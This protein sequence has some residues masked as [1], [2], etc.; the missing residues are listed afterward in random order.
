MRRA[1]LLFAVILL[2]LLGISF[3]YNQIT[4]YKQRA[5][6]AEIQAIV[7]DTITVTP[8]KQ[9]VEKNMEV[10]TSIVIP[11]LRVQAPIQPVGQDRKGRMATIPDPKT[12]AW[13][14]FGSAPGMPGNAILAG[15]RDWNGVLGTFWGIENLHSGD[16][17]SIQFSNGKRSVFKVVSDQTYLLQDVPSSVM[18]AA[19]P[20]R[21]TLITCVGDF[22]RSQG[23]YQ[24]RVVV[25]LQKVK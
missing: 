18:T 24:S 5:Q 16:S 10:P 19:G 4:H 2:S 8:V 25:I 13:Y 22:I 11:R 17:V 12:V 9:I 15:H 21:T 6:N 20:T 14:A 23:G 3:G 7:R 1:S